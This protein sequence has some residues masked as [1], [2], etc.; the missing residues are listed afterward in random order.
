[1]L[2]LSGSKLI[3]APSVQ[4]RDVSFGSYVALHR[5]KNNIK[6]L[7]LSGILTLIVPG[8]RLTL[9][10]DSKLSSVLMKRDTESPK[11]QNSGDYLDNPHSAVNTML[12]LA[13]YDDSK[14]EIIK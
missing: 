6:K 10:P 12:A 8:S 3:E 7:S 1:M 2:V 14:V 4:R 11:D 13:R 9:A 5:K